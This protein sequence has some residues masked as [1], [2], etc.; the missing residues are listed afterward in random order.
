M[1]QGG[2]MG[3]NNPNP[4][5][6]GNVSINVVDKRKKSGANMN[7]PQYQ[8]NMPPQNHPGHNNSS[9]SNQNSIP[10]PSNPQNNQSQGQA[11]YS[12]N[13]NLQQDQTA[14]SKGDVISKLTHLGTSSSEITSNI[15]DLLGL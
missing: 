8:G 10:A 15:K 4:M 1:G 6:D 9:N 11:V 13:V 7:Q 2:P 14:E 12:G 5:F 3:N